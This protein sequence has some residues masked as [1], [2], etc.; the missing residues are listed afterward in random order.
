MKKT[1]LNI[2]VTGSNGFIG[3][4]LVK[5]LDKLDA[6]NLMTFNRSENISILHRFINIHPMNRRPRRRELRT[7]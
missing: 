2:L 4:N 5:H 3:K 6:I 1:L 7:A